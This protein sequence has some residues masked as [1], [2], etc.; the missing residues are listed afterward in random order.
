MASQVIKDQKRQ[1]IDEIKAKISAASSI[2]LVDYK[3]LTVKQ[4][5]ELRS[6][7]RAAGVDY[8]VLKNRLVKIAFNELGYTQFDNDLEGPT[9]LAFGS[10]DIGAPAR[11]ALAGIKDYNKMSTKCGL[12]EG[13]FIDNGG[14]QSLAALPT[15]EV[16]LAKMLGSMLAPISKLAYVLK[17]ISEKGSESGAAAE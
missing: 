11:I 9:A 8:K 15:K 17:A 7:F 12:L 13:A 14:V 4:D 16:L 3:G 2:V 6:K 1:Q 10:S 5:T